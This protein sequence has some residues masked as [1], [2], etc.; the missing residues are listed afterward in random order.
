M[1]TRLPIPKTYK[2]FIGGQF[3]RT[4]SG[5][6]IKIA[7]AAGNTVAHACHA[8]RKDLRNAVEAAAGV[9]PKWAGATAYLRAQILYR[10]AEMMEG[11]AGELQAAI[12]TQ[13]GNEAARHQGTEVERAIDR[14]IH[15]A[16]WADKYTQ[17][18][19][20]ANPVA[21]PYHNFTVPEPVGVVGVVCPDAHPLLTLVS[22]VA[23]VVCAGNACVLLASETNP[24]PACILAEAIATSDMPGGV[25]NILTGFRD[26]LVPHFSSH[27]E[28]AAIHAAGVTPEQRKT[29]ELG[30]AENLKRVTV[31]GSDGGGIDWFDDEACEGPHW[32]EPF[33]E[34]KTIWHPSSA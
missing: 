3:P 13:E 4:E 11:K 23:P 8:S 6:S 29:L 15:Y 32:I 10:L 33:V 25:I 30:A 1:T 7:D 24:I 12:D 31:R 28:F 9:Q 21:G 14:V 22:L 18:L 17:V 27:R 26:E 20:C 5:R 19:G 2:L 34:F 16:G